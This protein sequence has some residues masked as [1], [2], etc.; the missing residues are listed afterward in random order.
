MSCSHTYTAHIQMRKTSAGIKLDLSCSTSKS[1][2]NLL[3]SIDQVPPENILLFIEHW[4]V[5]KILD[6]TYR[7]HEDH[8]RINAKLRFI[9]VIADTDCIPTNIAP[10]ALQTP[11]TRW[12]PPCGGPPEASL[13]WAYSFIPWP[14]SVQVYAWLVLASNSWL[15]AA[16]LPPQVA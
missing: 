4:L 12:R 16:T 9:K 5:F 11:A 8:F 14:S 2:T 3:D 13:L 10:A 6:K 15:N 1:H 7:K